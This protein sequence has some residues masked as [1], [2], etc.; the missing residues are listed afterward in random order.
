LQVAALMA[1]PLEVVLVA[2][3]LGALAGLLVC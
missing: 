3:T 1:A 2:W